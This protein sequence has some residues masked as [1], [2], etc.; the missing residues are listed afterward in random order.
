MENH[1]VFNFLNIE[2]FSE[3]L[4]GSRDKLKEMSA[5]WSQS[6]K[7]NSIDLPYIDGLG[8]QNKSATGAVE[9]V[10]PKRFIA[11]RNRLEDSEESDPDQD[12]DK[13]EEPEK[14]RNEFIVDEA[15]EIDGYQ[16]GDSMDS[17]ERREIEEN[18][19]DEE[20]RS[21]GSEDSAS[22][23][24][25]DD[26]N[27]S[28]IVPDDEEDDGTGSDPDDGKVNHCYYQKIPYFIIKIIFSFK[29][30][31]D[32]FDRLVSEPKYRR[33]IVGSDSESD[34]NDETVNVK[35]KSL[36]AAVLSG[37]KNTPTKVAIVVAEE[38]TVNEEVVENAQTETTAVETSPPVQIVITDAS[39]VETSQSNEA[40]ESSTQLSA[41]NDDFIV[42]ETAGPDSNAAEGE[43]KS[44]NQSGFK[45]SDRVS[46]EVAA[47][48]SKP[49][50]RNVS[51]SFVVED[52][53][54]EIAI[55]V[56]QSVSK[57]AAEFTET[58][59]AP[60]PEKEASAS[61][62]E[63]SASKV[64]ESTDSSQE[65]D[66]D[67][68]RIHYSLNK[69]HPK[70][71]EIITKALLNASNMDLEHEEAES[72]EDEQTPASSDKTVVDTAVSNNKS[73]AKV[74]NI[75]RK[76]ASDCDD[77]NI[78]YSFNEAHPANATLLRLMRASPRTEAT[79]DHINQGEQ[80][81]TVL[82][83]S[84][85][86]SAKANKSVEKTLTPKQDK[87]NVSA[88]QLSAAVQ[89]SVNRSLP[90][91]ENATSAF[92]TFLKKTENKTLGDME[93][94]QT[95]QVNPLSMHFDVNASNLGRSSTPN[96][97]A[98][99]KTR[100]VAATQSTAV[101][102]KEPSADDSA[103]A[104]STSI[105]MISRPN[106]SKSPRETNNNEDSRK[107]TPSG[108]FARKYS[109]SLTFHSFAFLPIHRR[110]IEDD[111][112]GRHFESLRI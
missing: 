101:E 91:D 75:E 88:N 81:P 23:D 1:F 2:P 28:F 83:S 36:V 32:E 102:P 78:L 27:D 106:V 84:A 42:S 48:S 56:N 9:E 18:E 55:A 15:D 29:M 5:N 108:M 22:G 4:K 41:V 53:P 47:S 85:N 99:L 74:K 11:A 92:K 16:S 71:V 30:L 111:Q 21:L 73:L 7:R 59:N 58:E 25:T 67:D 80:N 12:Q 35:N 40:S 26:E 39:I 105:S 8:V 68:D 90:G 17:E 104:E 97:K 98:L 34:D 82:N 52:T 49:K 60:T 38:P 65:G 44:A 76:Q 95:L 70:I 45:E 3:H 13:D 72:S 20:G 24:E 69:S 66:G 96:Q 61:M 94:N 33:M 14:P 103:P 62:A 109:V 50:K 107:D 43:N 63:E 37:S 86:A 112:P 93:T 57:V 46:P 64:H 100:A 87:E 51:M 110:S 79:K 10:T 89:S 31:S 77:D 54:A 19:I 6:I